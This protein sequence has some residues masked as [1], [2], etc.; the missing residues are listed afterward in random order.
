MAT[1]QFC[2]GASIFKTAEDQTSNAALVR[3]RPHL[4]IACSSAGDECPACADG[5][6]NIRLK[7]K[8]LIREYVRQA[9]GDSV[10]AYGADGAVLNSKVMARAAMRLMTA[11]RS[12]I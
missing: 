12:V 2:K 1:K 11:R 3:R 7:A 8:R 10:S 6:S 4:K 5:L 9:V